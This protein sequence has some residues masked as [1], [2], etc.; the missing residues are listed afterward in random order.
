MTN[1]TQTVFRA[2]ILANLFKVPSHPW[3]PGE[4]ARYRDRDLF[5]A[6]AAMHSLYELKNGDT[7]TDGVW[8]M[9]CR[10]VYEPIGVLHMHSN[11]TVDGVP[12][13]AWGSYPTI[14][15]IVKIAGLVQRLGVTL[16][17]QQLLSREVLREALYETGAICGLPTGKAGTNPGTETLSKTYHLTL[18][19]E[20][21]LSSSGTQ[22]SCPQMHG[23]RERTDWHS[24]INF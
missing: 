5:L 21:Y 7:G 4:H 18:W 3:G 23:K 17:G 13:T 19:H 20:P 15:D 10:E 2:I 6:G 12:L 1:L 8:G 14:D 11:T 22:Y 24:Q 9:L 16:D